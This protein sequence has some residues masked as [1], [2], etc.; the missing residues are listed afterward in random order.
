MLHTIREQHEV[1][2]TNVVDQFISLWLMIIRTH[3]THVI[4][5]LVITRAMS[6]SREVRLYPG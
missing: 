5:W 2:N 4:A 1:K 3:V 6:F